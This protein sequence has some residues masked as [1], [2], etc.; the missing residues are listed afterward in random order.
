MPPMR[1]LSPE[2]D[3]WWSGAQIYGTTPERNAQLRTGQGGQLLL[4][5]NG[6]YLALD[7]QCV[8]TCV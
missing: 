6:T 2:H 4:N 5:P 3:M 8:L 7:A 1:C